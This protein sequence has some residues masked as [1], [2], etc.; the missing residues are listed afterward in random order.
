MVKTLLYA[1]AN[2]FRSLCC[3]DSITILFIRIFLSSATWSGN[4]NNLKEGLFMFL[5]YVLYVLCFVAR[6]S[7]NFFI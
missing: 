6:F 3:S 7:I 2:D 1:V 5:C 4:L